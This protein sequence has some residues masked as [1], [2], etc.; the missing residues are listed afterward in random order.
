MSATFRC[1]KCRREFYI[2]GPVRTETCKKRYHTGDK[3]TPQTKIK[4]VCGEEHISRLIMIN[5]KP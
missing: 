1:R 3:L 4:C 2:E 5:W